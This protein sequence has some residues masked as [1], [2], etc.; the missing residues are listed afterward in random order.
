LP[1]LLSFHGGVS[2]A[3][4]V[5]GSSEESIADGF[6]GSFARRYLPLES[7]KVVGEVPSGVG[8]LVEWLESKG[9]AVESFDLKKDGMDRYVVRSEPPAPYVNESPVFFLLQVAARLY[10]KEGLLLFTDTIAFANPDSGE[11]VL[12]LGF[13]H[14]GKST[15][16]ALAAADGLAPLS[17]E[18]TVVRVDNDSA[19]VLGGS[20]VL[21]V[22][23]RAVERYLPPG[24][25]KPIGRTKHGYLI[26]DLDDSYDLKPY[27]INSIYVIHCSFASSGASFEPVTGRKAKKLLWHF[28]TSLLKGDDFYEPYSLCIE[29]GVEEIVARGISRMASLY[30]GQF[31]EVF[32]GHRDVYREIVGRSLRGRP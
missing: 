29:N 25:L 9:F 23:P 6:R 18:N 14:S 19:W 16:L 26:V 24:S 32:G 5:K 2:I 20:R 3:I 15:L 1:I 13:P 27:R 28:A 11:S 10:A 30:K 22:D 8:A 17:T 12:I 7:V 21:V 4:Q 31:Y